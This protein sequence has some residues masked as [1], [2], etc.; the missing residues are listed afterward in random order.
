[1]SE[2]KAPTLEERARLRELAE[3]A[4]IIPVTF[5]AS[6][7]VVCACL[8]AL[9]AAE[10]ERD[11]AERGFD[12]SKLDLHRA[13]QDAES[14]RGSAR[15]LSGL[16]DACARAARRDGNA[17]SVA[18]AVARI[19]RERDALVAAA[20]AFLGCHE[21]E[22]CPH[23]IA[24]RR[25]LDPFPK[26]ERDGEAMSDEKLIQR[27]RELHADCEICFGDPRLGRCES[28][29]LLAALEEIAARLV[30]VA[31][32]RDEARAEVER[33]TD[34]YHAKDAE[35]ASTQIELDEARAALE[36]SVRVGGEMVAR[37]AALEEALRGFLALHEGPRNAVGNWDAAFD[38][39]RAALAAPARGER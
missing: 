38:A 15:H 10:S 1:M 16:V 25:A 24:L 14:A 28:G 2:T 11:Q 22:D 23:T 6:A 13:E 33:L 36:T 39:A 20:R 7:N 32:E 19:V 30:L 3:N 37:V 9:D 12:Q 29:V 21:G 17:E 31:A 8:D 27:F 34:A 35:H 5:A 18:Q 4:P 26:A